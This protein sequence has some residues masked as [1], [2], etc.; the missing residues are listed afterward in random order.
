MFT[1]MEKRE[2]QG[3]AQGAGEG[4]ALEVG[5]GRVAVTFEKNARERLLS[6]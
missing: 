5:C 3:G 1:M 6:V 2:G 4:W